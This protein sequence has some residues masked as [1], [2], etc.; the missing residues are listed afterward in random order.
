MDA[1]PPPG[2]LRRRVTVTVCLVMFA[3]TASLVVFGVLRWM[4]TGGPPPLTLVSVALLSMFMARILIQEARK[5]L[6]REV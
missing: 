2:S 3:L 4:R 5:Q 1:L 6:R